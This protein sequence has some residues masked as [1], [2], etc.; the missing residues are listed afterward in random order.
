[1]VGIGVIPTTVK[2]DEL[3]KECEQALSTKMSITLFLTK[4]LSLRASP[5]SVLAIA[6]IYNEP[7]SAFN[8]SSSP[9]VLRPHQ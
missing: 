6:L 5:S 1:L 7:N 8:V 3:T 9:A 2:K 4:A